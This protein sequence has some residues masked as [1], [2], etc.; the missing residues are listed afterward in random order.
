MNKKEIIDAFRGKLVGG[1]FVKKMIAQ[2]ILKLPENIIHYL[3]DN[4]WFLSSSPESFAYTFK[5]NDLAGQ[6]MIF[7][8]DELLAEPR[9]QI[10]YTI[11]HEIG[12]VMLKHR[13]AI[14]YH[15]PKHEIA[16]QEFEADQFANQYL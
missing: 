7:I 3:I 12:H 8:S 2:T 9:D 15:Q 4:V 10:E 11:L 6:H 1:F 13:N 14:N 5:G 16:K